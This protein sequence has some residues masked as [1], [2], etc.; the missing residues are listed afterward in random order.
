[1]RYVNSAIAIIV[2]LVA[3]WGGSYITAALGFYHWAYFPTLLTQ[4][5]GLFFGIVYAI[6]RW[7]E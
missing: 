6:K 5:F 1:M 3:L 2:A 7:P 4:W